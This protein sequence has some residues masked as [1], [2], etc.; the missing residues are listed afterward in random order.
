[1]LARRARIPEQLAQELEKLLQEGVWGPGVQI[2]PER[3]LAQRFG[4]SRASVRDALRILE[5]YGWL[6]I[7]QGEGTRV[8]SSA[9]GFGRR[10]RTRLHEP[11][12]VSELFELRRILEPTVAALAAERAEAEDLEKLEG[13]LKQQKEATKD[14]HKFL[15][16]DL[17][18]HKAL[19][20]CAHNGLLVE[21]L[22]LLVV[23]LRQTRLSATARRFRPLN[24][25]REH[26]RIVSAVRKGDAEEAQAAMLAHLSTV[27]RSAFAEPKEVA[28]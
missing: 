11:S 5:L 14:L 20:E 12:F 6:E 26:R 4:V 13:L 9:V 24:T 3:E 25:L 2:P 22:Q 10:L 21:V 7:R 16:L 18:F 23:E 28:R 1:M 15:E 17:S 19:A 8:A 27:E